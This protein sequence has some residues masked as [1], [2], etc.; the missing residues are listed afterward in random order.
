MSHVLVICAKRYNGHELWTLLGVLQ[1]RE[2]TFEVVSQE[3]LIRD[4]LT[5]RPNTIERTVYE[6]YNTFEHDAVCIVS[7]NMADT[8]AYWTDKHVINLLEGFRAAEKVCAA[9][10]CSVPTLAPIVHGIKVSYFPLVRSRHRLKNAG[11]ILQ[12]TS[13]TIDGLFA[14]AE[15]Q[16]MTEMW[17]EEICNLLEG[18]PVQ[19]KMVDSGFT[20]KGSERRMDPVVR[21]AIDEDRGY[22]MVFHTDKET[23]KKL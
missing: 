23:G 4:E 10:C 18:K 8:E 22:E 5:L 9:I 13:L 21:A 14:T 20:P 11:A 3:T 15:N 12:N 1:E 7:G 16:M 2:H 6:V 19:Y 17:A